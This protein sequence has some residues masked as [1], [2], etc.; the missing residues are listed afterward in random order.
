MVAVVA[1]ALGGLIILWVNDAAGNPVVGWFGKWIKSSGFAGLGAIV[2]A[3]IAF[4]GISLQLQASRE[5]DADSAWWQSFEWASDRGLPRDSS[6]LR[7]S[8]EAAVDTL[9]ALATAARTDIQKNAVS[10]VVDELIR[11]NESRARGQVSIASDLEAQPTVPDV[12]EPVLDFSAGTE[13]DQTGA[14]PDPDRADSNSDGAPAAVLR[15]VLE[16]VGTAAESRRAN[17]SAYEAGVLRALEHGY[18][19]V[20]RLRGGAAG[21]AIVRTRN[22]ELAVE[23][24]WSPNRILNMSG[25]PSAGNIDVVISNVPVANLAPGVAQ[26]VWNER[27]KSLALRKALDAIE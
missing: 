15:Y 8:F 6:E 21:D 13:P 14:E 4:V 11:S 25:R 23:I 3:S 19:R 18:G 20:L 27:D 24:K 26:V 9:N 12:E 16:Q 10:G 7:L 22:R 1:G 2:A 5:R 17:A